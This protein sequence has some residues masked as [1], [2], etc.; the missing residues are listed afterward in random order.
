[1]KATLLLM[2][3]LCFGLAAG[4]GVLLAVG[5]APLWVWG[6]LAYLTAQFLGITLSAAMA[7]FRR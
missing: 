4:G 7:T 1:M 5:H 2:W 3:A 6:A